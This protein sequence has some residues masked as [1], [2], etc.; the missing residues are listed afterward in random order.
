MLSRQEGGG[1]FRS[2]RCRQRARSRRRPPLPHLP[3]AIIQVWAPFAPLVSA[4]VWVQ[5]Q[6]WRVG[7]MLTP[8]PRTGTAA[9]RVMGWAAERPVTI[10]PRVV[11]RATWSAR[12]GRRRLWGGLLTWLLSPGAPSVVG[13][14]E[15]VARRSGRQITAKGCDREAV[16]SAQTHVIRCVGLP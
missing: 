16:R 3:A 6:R 4:R 9:L 10:D 15:T 8:G 14:D 2:R 12:P 7:A 11:N 13:A 1:A 5:A